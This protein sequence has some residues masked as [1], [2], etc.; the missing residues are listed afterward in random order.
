MI[1]G[2]FNGVCGVSGVYG[3]GC[4]GR[5][6]GQGCFQGR[7]KCAQPCPFMRMHAKPLSAGSHGNDMYLYMR[8]WCS[9][10]YGTRIG[11]N[12]ANCITS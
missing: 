5:R 3:V 6:A 12:S 10:V 2:V 11:S 7:P 4:A 8:C 9:L 1:V